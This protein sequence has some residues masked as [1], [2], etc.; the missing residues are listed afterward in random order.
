MDLQLL[1]PGPMTVLPGQLRPVWLR[2][3]SDREGKDDVR[4]ELLRYSAL[5]LWSA[6]GMV[7]HLR[8]YVRI[9]VYTLPR[10]GRLLK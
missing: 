4:K 9:F 3:H 2:D 7:R 8:S 5:R 1:P 10:L 6:Q